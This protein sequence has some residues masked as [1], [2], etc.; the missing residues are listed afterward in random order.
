[1]VAV[2]QELERLGPE[3]SIIVGR[4][5]TKHHEEYLSG[6]PT[7]VLQQLDTRNGVKGELAILVSGA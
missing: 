7:E 3:R 4:E 2:L 1:V 5:M 6:S